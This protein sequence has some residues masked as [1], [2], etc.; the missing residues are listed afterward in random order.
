MTTVREVMLTIENELGLHARAATM[1]VQVASKFDAD[2]TVIK[3]GREVNG[4][5]IM[6]VLTLVASKGTKIQVRAE[7]RQA[8]EVLDAISK[9]V[10]EK[11]GEEM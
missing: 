7:G 6:G 3:D 9:L 10:A 8:S 11:F 1:F 4:K 2:I 5:S